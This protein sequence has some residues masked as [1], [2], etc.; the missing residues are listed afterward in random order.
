MS[1]SE[2]EKDLAAWVANL[3]PSE[4]FAAAVAQLKSAVT[5][6]PGR[7]SR[8]Y[9]EMLSGYTNSPEALVKVTATIHESETYSGLVSALDI[10][11]TSIC[12]HHFLPF[13]GTVDV[14]YQ[15]GTMIVGIGKL[16]RFVD[17]RA[18]RFQIQ[19]FLVKETCND[20][21]QHV[22]ARG[23]YVRAVARHLCVCARG[24]NRPGVVNITS[25]GMGTLENYGL[26]PPVRLGGHDE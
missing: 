16:P 22:G 3:Y 2:D 24:P 1:D 26:R 9:Q 17:M 5:E 13:F 23:A 6:S 15:P 4:A 12:A 18:R 8:A 10:P 20:L 25:Y 7:I 14:V 19:E 21:I 11:F